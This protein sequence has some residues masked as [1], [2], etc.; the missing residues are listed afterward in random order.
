MKKKEVK[1]AA[2]SA[3]GIAPL[4]AADLQDHLLAVINDLDHL[5]SLLDHAC[6]TLLEGFLGV[7]Q[8]LDSL[9]IAKPANSESIARAGKHLRSA[10]KA[11]QFQD[12]SSQLI[13]H[14]AK[15]LRHCADRLASDAFSGD[16]GEVAAVESAP[17]RP[18]PVTQA[19]MDTGYIELF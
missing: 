1:E 11:L 12:M 2:P 5:Q 9:Q 4:V 7:N 17:L 14:T 6:S 18:N 10:A 13:A 15:R 16:D 8:Q 3:D 19:Q